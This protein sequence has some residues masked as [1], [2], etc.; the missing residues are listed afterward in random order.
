MNND[1]N[2]INTPDV[3]YSDVSNNYKPKKFKAVD[4]LIFV[5]CLILAFAFWCYAIYLDDPIIE[6]KVT[7]NLIKNKKTYKICSL[8]NNIVIR[9][10][11]RIGGEI[12]KIMTKIKILCHV[13]YK[14]TRFMW[15]EYHFLV[16]PKLIKKYIKDFRTS[17]KGKTY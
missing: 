17:L 11:S 10:F 9:I 3:D 16:P 14:G 2:V 15:R 6:K 12:R 7:V 1:V 4:I 13:L 8:N 5:V